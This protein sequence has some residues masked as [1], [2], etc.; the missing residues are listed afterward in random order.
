MKASF[1]LIIRDFVEGYL[2]GSRFARSEFRKAFANSI[3]N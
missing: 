2:F 1:K 3:L